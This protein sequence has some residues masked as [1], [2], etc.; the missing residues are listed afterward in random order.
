M[1]TSSMTTPVRI[2]RIGESGLRW[3]L[4]LWRRAS[5][6]QDVLR[7]SSGCFWRLWLLLER[8]PTKVTE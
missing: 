8:K 2:R 5:A 7:L 6:W 1:D 3:R 4:T